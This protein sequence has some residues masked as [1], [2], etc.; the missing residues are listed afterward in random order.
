[1]SEDGLKTATMSQPEA[2][3]YDAAHSA[4]GFKTKF[5]CSPDFTSEDRMISQ[6]L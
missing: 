4:R 6:T 1:M 3:P 2:M 5:K